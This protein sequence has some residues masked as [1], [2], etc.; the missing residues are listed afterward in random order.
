[1]NTLV[2]VSSILHQNFSLHRSCLHL[3]TS[4]PSFESFDRRRLGFP[5]PRG[6][7]VPPTRRRRH[8][9]QMTK[10]LRPHC[11]SEPC[12]N[13]AIIMFNEKKRSSAFVIPSDVDEEHC[14]KRLRSADPD[15]KVVVGGEA[16]YHYSMVLSCGSEYFDT[17]LSSD[18]KEGQAKVVE[19]PDKSPGE[20]RRVFEFFGPTVAA[21]E[22]TDE[23]C[24]TLLPWFSEL[25]MT[26]G[27]SRCDNKLRVSLLEKTILLE[28]ELSCGASH[29]DNKRKQGVAIVKEILEKA[30]ICSLYSLPYAMKD[31]L[32]IL[33]RIIEDKFLFVGSFESTS[34]LVEI[35]KDETS[36]EYLLPVLTKKFAEFSIP[37]G[38]NDD[39]LRSPLLP[40]MLL[41]A[42]KLDGHENSKYKWSR[43]Y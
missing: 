6:T 34:K 18:M 16:F 15:V 21:K 41:M 19:F 3:R 4:Q 5:F 42:V 2:I 7:Q 40:S 37:L 26:V 25:R 33:R 1:M 22:L 13:T 20:W 30:E 9:D 23:D 17:M 39:F 11:M 27:L 29:L 14:P 24:R 8:D 43:R 36:R 31:C 38:T 32:P 12:E 28:R 10:Q 35:L